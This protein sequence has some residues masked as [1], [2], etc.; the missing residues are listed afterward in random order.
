MDILIA[1]TA[2]ATG[3]GGFVSDAKI[4]FYGISTHVIAYANACHN[5]PGCISSIPYDTETRPY[6]IHTNT[7]YE[8]QLTASGFMSSIFAG[9]YTAV[10]DPTITIDPNGGDLVPQGATLSYSANLFAAVI[11]EPVTF[12]LLLGGMAI[13][14]MIR[15]HTGRTSRHST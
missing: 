6:F 14:A 3:S 4:D 5:S 13:T 11:P 10:A 1:A 15:R 12:S 8:I 2:A 9:S 7:A